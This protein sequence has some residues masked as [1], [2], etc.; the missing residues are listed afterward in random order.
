M[1]TESS[2]ANVGCAA[3]VGN[4]SPGQLAM[5]QVVVSVPATNRLIPSSWRAEK[6]SGVASV[7]VN[8][9]T[10]ACANPPKLKG[11]VRHAAEVQVAGVGAAGVS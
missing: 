6:V 4:R 1:L 2:T 10:V 3:D 7:N 9:K 11:L 5:V 8:R